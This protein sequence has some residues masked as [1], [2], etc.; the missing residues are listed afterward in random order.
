MTKQFGI[1]FV[2]KK[3]KICSLKIGENGKNSYLYIDP[4]FLIFDLLDR[5]A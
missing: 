5:Q 3:I 2:F 1:T 4:M